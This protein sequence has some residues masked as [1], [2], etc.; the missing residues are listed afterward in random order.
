MIFE[1]ILEIKYLF[2][3]PRN[4]S[5]ILTLLL[6]I[7]LRV[8]DLNQNTPLRLWSCFYQL[9]ALFQ[10]EAVEPSPEPRIEQRARMFAEESQYS[11]VA[12]GL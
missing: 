8:L 12:A 6:L 1:K 9:N 10:K 4:A 3:Y 11:P 5:Q 2:N 7:M